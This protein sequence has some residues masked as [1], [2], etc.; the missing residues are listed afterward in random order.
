M[1][2]L[3]HLDL[4]KNKKQPTLK[5]Y[6]D[7]YV[8]R[9]MTPSDAKIVQEWHQGIEKISRYD[10]DICLRIYPSGHGFYIGE[11]KDEVVAS[12][13]R[14]P[15]GDNL[16]Y[17]S[18]YYVNVKSRGLGFGTR[19]RDEVARA[20]VGDSMLCVDAMLGKVAHKNEEEF[21]YKSAFKTGRFHCA[22]RA[23]VGI[24]YKGKIVGV[25]FRFSS[26]S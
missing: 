18:Y 20:Y 16:F 19:L 15:W 7:G 22:A 3:L 12:A 8:V 11:Y 9:I 10:L 2:G 26:K 23:D 4:N 24:Q 6:A 1:L 5:E 17:G 14:I 21:G 13:I 25:R